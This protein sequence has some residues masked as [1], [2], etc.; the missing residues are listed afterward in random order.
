M[1]DNEQK[2]KPLRLAK[3][4][5][6]PRPIFI[7]KGN[8]LASTGQD[9]RFWAHNFPALVRRVGRKSVIVADELERAVRG[10]GVPL[11]PDA[12]PVDAAEQV[13]QLLRAGGRR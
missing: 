8:S 5:A 2:S 1:K 6:S 11:A 3:A 10:A 9:L 12:P 4:E 13:R 7:T